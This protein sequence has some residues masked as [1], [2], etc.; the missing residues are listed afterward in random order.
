MT[1]RCGIINTDVIAI[2]SIK[3]Y[4]EK[5]PETKLVLFSQ[6]ALEVRSQINRNVIDLL[7]LDVDLP[8]ISGLDF[9]QTL[10]KPPKIILTASVKRYA[11]DAFD[12]EVLDY[13]VRPITLQRF[14]S[15]IKKFQKQNHF[16]NHAPSTEQFFFLKENKKMVKVQIND[17]L[18][19]ES[20]KDYIKVATKN[21]TVITKEQISHFYANL[22]YSS[23]IR[24]HRS[25][26]V[27]INKIDAYSYSFI[28][29]DGIE[30]PIGRN[31]KEECIERLDKING[32]KSLHKA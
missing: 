17:I 31:Y 16:M 11:A 6:N 32:Q 8:D 2:S 14:I 9:L 7:F 19:V 5:L 25:F 24:P 10:T 27:N 3:Q 22:P 30:I 15:A 20:I 23:F 18:Y 29:I 21:R 4:I 13:L 1:I 26:L 28:E 12:L